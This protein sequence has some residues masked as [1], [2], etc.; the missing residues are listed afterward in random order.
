[1]VL[2]DVWC[3]VLCFGVVL[4]EVEQGDYV[5][6]DFCVIVDVI[7]GEDDG[8]FFVYEVYFLGMQD[9]DWMGLVGVGIV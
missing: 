6:V 2:G 7:I 9:L 1:M 5:F 4:V 8:N 3:E